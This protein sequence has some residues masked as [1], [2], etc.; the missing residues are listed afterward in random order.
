MQALD[1]GSGPIQDFSFILSI[2]LMKLISSFTSFLFLNSKEYKVVRKYFRIFA[3]TTGST[4]HET[5]KRG[6]K[7]Y[8]IL[9]LNYITYQSLPFIS[10]ASVSLS[11]SD[12]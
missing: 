5:V 3:H 1:G 7:L 12:E 10:S 9:D 11:D 4:L 6:L 2:L 8:V